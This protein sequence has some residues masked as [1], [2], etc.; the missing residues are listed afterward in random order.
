MIVNLYIILGAA[1][2]YIALAIISGFF[3]DN[4]M[5]LAITAGTMQPMMVY[6]GVVLVLGFVICFFV[7]RA[8]GK[9]GRG[10]FMLNT[11]MHALM[12]AALVVLN[13][14]S[15]LITVILLGLSGIGGDP[16]SFTVVDK[17]MMPIVL[18]PIAAIEIIDAV[19]ATIRVRELSLPADADLPVNPLRRREKT[20]AV[21]QAVIIYIEAIVAVLYYLIASVVT[22]LV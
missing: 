10:R 1:L 16:K 19:A 8:K 6:G 4:L 3:S 15:Y 9:N 11:Q 12:T 7:T 14:I 2:A 18:A 13:V 20:V 5:W 21:I 17:I 22:L